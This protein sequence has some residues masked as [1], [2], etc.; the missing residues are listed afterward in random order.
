[1]C[2]Y[3]HPASIRQVII[4]MLSSVFLLPLLAAYATASSILPGAS[5]DHR[6]DEKTFNSSISSGP[7]HVQFLSEESGLDGS[8]L[9]SVNASVFDWWYFDAVAEDRN[10]SF[11]I[12]FFTSSYNAFPFL[13]QVDNVLPVYIWASFPNGTVTTLITHAENATIK[14]RGNGSEGR[15]EPIGMGWKGSEDLSKHVITVDDSNLGIKGTFRIESVRLTWACL[16]STCR[17]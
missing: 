9:S 5:I 11:V 7:S 3:Q 16:K 14:T 1:M 10:S 2:I 13:Q 12:I 4:T 6:P 8:K 15:Y 17:V